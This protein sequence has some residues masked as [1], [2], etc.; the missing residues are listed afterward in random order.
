MTG[1]R[2]ARAPSPPPVGAERRSA[3][4]DG[5]VL[6]AAVLALVLSF[7]GYY[8]YDVADR[9][10]S[11]CTGTT[12]SLARHLCAGHSQ[13]AWHGFFGWFGVL[14]AVVAALLVAAARWV[15]NPGFSLPARWAALGLFGL[16][17]LGTLLALGSVPNYR[18]A[19]DQ[20]VRGGLYAELI[21]EGHGSCYWAVLALIVLGTVLA[22]LQ[23]VQAT[24]TTT[25]RRVPPP[26][27]P[28]PA[29]VPSE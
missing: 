21:D 7:F 26:S 18:F 23:A 16:A 6:A 22:G 29:E 9:F 3:A 17:T 11:R 14:L 19:L 10:R 5:A 4:L 20:G 15:P 13:S 12:T 1:Y 24:G 2:P 28:G 27:A 25:G 8:T